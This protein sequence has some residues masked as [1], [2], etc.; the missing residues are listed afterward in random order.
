MKR[1]A[2]YVFII[3][4]M[5]IS[6]A[7]AKNMSLKVSNAKIDEYIAQNPDLPDFDKSCLMSGEFKVGIQTGTLKL[8]L[9]EPKKIT[10]IKQAWAEQEEWFYKENGKLYFT[11]ENGGVVGIE[12]R[13]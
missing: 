9:G 12:E 5:C 3:C 11:I 7:S 2:V 1:L 10:K 13:K 4:A 6:F 8:M